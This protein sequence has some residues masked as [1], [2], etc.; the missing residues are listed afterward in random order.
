MESIQFQYCSILNDFFCRLIIRK[1][2]RLEIHFSLKEYE[3]LNYFSR[4]EAKLH[5]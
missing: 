1:S 2:E 5:K 3:L 4:K